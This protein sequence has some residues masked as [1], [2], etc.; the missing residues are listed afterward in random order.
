MESFRRFFAAATAVVL[1]GAVCPKAGRAGDDDAT[2]QAKKL[3]K[4]EEKAQG[5]YD[6]HYDKFLDQTIEST[7][8]LNVRKPMG[9][10]KS[11]GDMAIQICWVH[12]GAQMTVRP[13][14]IQLVFT[15][16]SD[17]GPF[18]KNNRSLAF[19]LDDQG[20]P[21]ADDAVEYNRDG[22][23]GDSEEIL[24]YNLTLDQFLKIARAGTIKGRLGEDEFKV[25]D[26][27]QI[28]F[29]EVYKRLA[30]VPGEAAPPAP[31]GAAPAAPAG[32]APAAPPAPVAP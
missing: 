15:V 13:A 14:T 27:E 22:T 19:L 9:I 28:C 32:A 29:R 30:A 21:V 8:P 20:F 7:K 6:N 5:N 17:A 25:K 3:A 10:F 2:K 31:V 4:W 24:K 23:R 18:Y 12:K 16:W 11:P 1:L 26:F